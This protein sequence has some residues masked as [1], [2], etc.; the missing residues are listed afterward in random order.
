[1]W[2]VSTSTHASPVGAAPP[3]VV[4]PAP[5]P[6]RTGGEELAMVAVRGAEVET[7]T[8]LHHP[9]RVGGEL[10]QVLAGVDVHEEVE[11]PE[12][13]LGTVVADL[14]RREVERRAGR[15]ADQHARLDRGARR[16][17][18]ARN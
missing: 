7:A 8:A 13:H 12:S 5:H 14:P 16:Y 18:D 11:H 1:M 4:M 9:T 17:V 10:A 3:R 15:H 2:P 6:S